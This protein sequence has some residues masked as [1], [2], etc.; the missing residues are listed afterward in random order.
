MEENTAGTPDTNRLLPALA[1]CAPHSDSNL[2]HTHY[3]VNNRIHHDKQ[4]NASC[5]YTIIP[6]A[7]G[8]IYH[9]LLYTGKWS[10]E[11]VYPIWW[12]FKAFVL[13]S[14]HISECNEQHIHI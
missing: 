12:D 14:K 2:C 6:S 7:V 9:A 10:A 4:P 11:D 5:T 8:A 3:D 13:A 1:P